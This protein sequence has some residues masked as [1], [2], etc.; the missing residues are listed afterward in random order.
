LSQLRG[1]PQ[2]VQAAG[3]DD[4]I[5]GASLLFCR[6]MLSFIA[7]RAKEDA[8]ALVR[9]S[10][11][12]LTYASL[13]MASAAVMQALDGRV[14]EISR[15]LVGIAVTD[16]AGFVAS[17]LAVLEAGGV[18]MPLDLSRGE[19][20]LQDEVERLR[21][22]A[23]IVG[24]AAE[25][26]LDILAG[27]AARRELPAESALA[28][29]S[30]GKRAIAGA[31]PL[32][33]AVDAI[34]AAS[35][36]TAATRTSLSGDL[37]RPAMLVPLLA[38]LRAGG[39]LV[40]GGPPATTLACDLAETLRIGTF[41]EGILR[42]LPGC[43]FVFADGELLVDCPWAMLGYLDDD[44]ATRAAFVTRDGKSLVRASH[45]IER[46]LAAQAGVR[47]AA[48]LAFP[49]ADGAR[50][51]GFVAGA[52]ATFGGAK[53]ATLESLPHA[54]DGTIDRVKLRRMSSAD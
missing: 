25:D 36:W 32:G 54:G 18:A 47:E 11:E 12:R 35:G 50:L 28:L 19:A 17:L 53:V 6:A 1:S 23:V 44:A 3:A 27:D 16:A 46:L 49:Y 4:S 8:D 52:D 51:A 37:S 15:R 26:R 31:R 10:G 20:A 9:P 2:K 29:F 39:T 30:D 7:E 13:A 24:D 40:D 14:G 34:V 33:L 22:V 43:D 45:A 48:V 42:P 41:A 21:A 5:A 38:T